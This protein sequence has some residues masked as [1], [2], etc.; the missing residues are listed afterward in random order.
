MTKKQKNIK[1]QELTTLSSVKKG[2]SKKSK[3]KYLKNFCDYI[4]KKISL[5][6]FYFVKCKNKMY[7]YKTLKL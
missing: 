1:N 2:V 5:S 6:R 4:E 3:I 7:I